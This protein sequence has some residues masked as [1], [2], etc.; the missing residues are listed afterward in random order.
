MNKRY[1]T[2]LFDLDGTLTDS[3]EGIIKSVQYALHKRGIEVADRRELIPFIGPPLMYSFQHFYGLTES[4]A[5]E[6]IQDYREYFERDGMYDNRVYDGITDVLA[7]LKANGKTLLVA[8][9]KP[10][11]YADPIVRHYGMG[12]YFKKI[13]GASTDGTRTEKGQV[14]AEA[15]RYTDDPKESVLMIGDREHDVIGARE[16]G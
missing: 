10:E 6:S 8:T 11:I 12:E 2:I 13:I 5:R 3:Q 15:L 7:M 16:H 9:S 14:I 1:D 4:E